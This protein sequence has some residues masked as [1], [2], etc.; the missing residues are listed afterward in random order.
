MMIARVR[1]CVQNTEQGRD[2]DFEN[3]KCERLAWIAGERRTEGSRDLV[4]TRG[5][6][7]EVPR[8]RGV[9]PAV[10]MEDRHVMVDVRTSYC[11]I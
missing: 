11:R 3:V 1:P 9:E 4:L 6:H 10:Y 7:E 2:I 8:R 5:T